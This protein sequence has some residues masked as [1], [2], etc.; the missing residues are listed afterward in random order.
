M[1]FP[2]EG[3]FTSSHFLP[4]IRSLRV[5]KILSAILGP[6]MAAPILRTPGKCVRSAGKAKSIKFLVLVG[7]GVFWGLGG[8]SA[9][10]I[11]MG[12][13]I[14]FQKKRRPKICLEKVQ[15]GNAIRGNK[16]ESL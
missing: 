6:E 1:T 4:Q 10:F 5:R 9:D 8:G 13:R 7:G 16:T 15:R 12:A 11:F 3:R 2:R 14:F